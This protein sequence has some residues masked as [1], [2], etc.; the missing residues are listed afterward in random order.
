MR[1]SD[2]MFPLLQPW[3]CGCR[4]QQHE[5]IVVHVSCGE[6]PAPQLG[7]VGMGFTDK[8][9]QGQARCCLQPTS[10]ETS[11]KTTRLAAMDQQ[12][13][14]CVQVYPKTREPI[15]GWREQVR[16]EIAPHKARRQGGDSEY[17]RL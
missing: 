9:G 14:V 8:P 16:T 7:R 5:S 13:L 11:P 4:K 1:C 10:D 6:A 2:S 3:S 17:M 12:R 15:L